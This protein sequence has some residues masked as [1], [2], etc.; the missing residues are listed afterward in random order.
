MLHRVALPTCTLVMP[1]VL[2]NCVPVRSPLVRDALPYLC[3]P[4]PPCPHLS[5]GAEDET[6]F[7]PEFVLGVSFVVGSSVRSGALAERVGTEGVMLQYAVDTHLDE[8][9]ATVWMQVGG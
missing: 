3:C 7:I 1:S 4:P 5:G 8:A 9:L 2:S 6:V